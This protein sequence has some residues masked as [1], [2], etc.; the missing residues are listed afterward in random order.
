MRIVTL[1]FAIL[2]AFTAA[3][4]AEDFQFGGQTLSISPPPGYCALD[5]S[6]PND[7]VVIKRL[8]VQ[9]EG[10][11]L[12][13]LQFGICNELADWRAGR[14]PVLSRYGQIMLP[15]SY[16]EAPRPLPMSRQEYLD[17]VAPQIP[18]VD[19]AQVAE[20]ES[21]LNA[22]TEDVQIS[23]IQNLGIL[24]QDENAI[25]VGMLGVITGG[26]QKL[27]VAAVAAATL[28]ESIP[29]TVNLYGPTDEGAFDKLVA[30]QKA[31]VADLI[32][33]NP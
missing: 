14:I 7:A 19:A 25:Y 33:R 32:R 8:E 3:G 6:D 22:R 30:I 18:K 26:G 24:D 2:L 15:L 31:Y 13:P 27:P 4:A 23:S 12:V 16:A 21:K 28:L 5:P 11:N 9:Q 1:A 10:M 17:T 29:V 20:L